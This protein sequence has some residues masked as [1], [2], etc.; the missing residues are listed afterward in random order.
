MDPVSLSVLAAS[1]VVKTIDATEL[2][3]NWLA[4]RNAVGAGQALPEVQGSELKTRRVETLK[5]LNAL[6]NR[7]TFCITDDDLRQNVW[8]ILIE[9]ALAIY[10]AKNDQALEETLELVDEGLNQVT[11][12]VD[13]YAARYEHLRKIRLAAIIISVIALALIV[14]YLFVANNLGITTTTEVMLLGLPVPIILWSAIGSYTAILYRFSLSSDNKMPNPLAWLF[15]R[16]LTGVVMGSITYLVI[17]VGMMSFA[18]G[19]PTGNLGAVQLMW[20]VAFVAGFS[21]RFSDNLLRSLIGKMGGDNNGEIVSM[22]VTTQTQKASS[23]DAIL[24]F[25]N[26]RRLEQP[27][28][29]AEENNGN[30][31][32][33]AGNSGAALTQTN[34]TAPVLPNV[35]VKPPHKNGVEAAAPVGLAQGET[36]E[37]TVTNVKVETKKD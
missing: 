11:T 22:E 35:D 4:S 30:K 17:K 7:V 33:A 12:I 28:G 20:L 3:K 5:K 21:D 15:S 25:L 31:S 14:I 27:A 6:R 9:Q 34:T 24:N 16:P 8:R 18:P 36:V 26:K 2:I 37:N 32:I 23:F 13:S 1:S 19:T 10:D 29:P